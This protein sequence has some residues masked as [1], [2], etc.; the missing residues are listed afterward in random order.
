MATNFPPDPT[1]AV[2]KK[3][4]P[5][6]RYNKDMVM[7]W[8]YVQ[9]QNTGFQGTFEEFEVIYGDKDI[10]DIIASYTGEYRIIP[11]LDVDY[12]LETKDKL[13]EGN[14]IVE[15]IP[16]ELIM[17]EHYAGNYSVTPMAE[18]DQILRTN[19]KMMDDDITVEKIPFHK[20]SNDAGGYTFTI[21]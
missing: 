4:Y 17:K 2:L 13:M 18:L 10:H 1:N 15:K 11:Q 12:V 8:L 14:V 5:W 16:E 9:A 6:S 7:Q 21:G 3:I 20:V 19:N